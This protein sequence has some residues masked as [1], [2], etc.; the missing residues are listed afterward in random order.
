VRP[1]KSF[2]LF[3]HLTLLVATLSLLITVATSVLVTM[4]THVQRICNELVGNN[5][6][7]VLVRFSLLN[8]DADIERI[9]TAM[10]RNT[11]L[12]RDGLWLDFREA[13]PISAEAA[14]R[15]AEAMVAHRGLR[16][17]WLFCGDGEFQAIQ[18][19]EM[20]RVLCRKTPLSLNLT[21]LDVDIA[22]VPSLRLLL[23][24]GS[25]DSLEIQAVVISDS[26]PVELDLADA[27]ARNTTLRSL[28][29]SG[30]T[31]LSLATLQEI[32]LLLEKNTLEELFLDCQETPRFSAVLPL[33]LL[34]VPRCQSLTD[35]TLLY[36]TVRPQDIKVLGAMLA[37]GRSLR[38]VRL[39]LRSNGPLDI[40]Q[41]AN[42]LASETCA[43]ETLFWFEQV[44]GI[45]VAH[46]M[47]RAIRDNTSLTTLNL[48]CPRDVGQDGVSV[49]AAAFHHNSVIEDF[50]VNFRLVDRDG[51]NAFGRMLEV[52]TTLKSLV[53]ECAQ[54]DLVAFAE[55]LPRM[56]H[57]R[58][59]TFRANNISALATD[60]IDVMFAANLEVNTSLE[61]AFIGR[62]GSLYSSRE[63]PRFNAILQRNRALNKAG[64]RVLKTEVDP[65]PWSL[66]LENS[67]D[68]P[69]T[70]FFLFVRSFLWCS[71][72]E[73]RRLEMN[74]GVVLWCSR[75]EFRRLEMNVGVVPL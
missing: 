75:V 48:C 8:G 61:K 30:R 35:F 28:C 15:F 64:W 23:T 39:Q 17:L 24:E 18:F 42:G 16:K 69:D 19:L 7:G 58:E 20:A 45:Q 52:N 74:V 60:D 27:L 40:Q 38:K 26:E 2:E 6:T 10:G 68:D 72:V 5:E 12:F 31:P 46:G 50:T 44:D 59:L 55:Q 43:I 49:L 56:A 65:V 36:W 67:N 4:N 34:T 57:L 25:I 73:F 51:A 63:M 11:T 32:P 9:V 33:I 1:K 3:S 29:I 22:Y 13:I 71:R 53:L 21:F 54:C 62:Q 14:A 41:L 66:A 47:A 37:N 70:V